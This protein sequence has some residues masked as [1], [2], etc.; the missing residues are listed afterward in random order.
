MKEFANRCASLKS[1][2]TMADTDDFVNH[3]VHMVEQVVGGVLQPSSH[4]MVAPH[5]DSLGRRILLVP[6]KGT[7]LP[8]NGYLLV[9]SFFLTFCVPLA[10]NDHKSA[11]Y[12][13]MLNSEEHR[14]LPAPKTGR[15]SQDEFPE[16]V[17]RNS[18]AF[19]PDESLQ[20]D[21]DGEDSEQA[22]HEVEE[23]NSAAPDE[24]NDE[25]PATQ[26]GNDAEKPRLDGGDRNGMHPENDA[27][28]TLETKVSIET[29][30]SDYEAQGDEWARTFVWSDTEC[31]LARFEEVTYVTLETIFRGKLLLTTDSVYFRVDDGIDVFSKEVVQ[32]SN[33][34]NFLRYRLGKLTEIHGR[35]YLLRPQALELFFVDCQ[36]VFFSFSSHKERNR[37]YAK[38]KNS[39]KA[40]LLSQTTSLNPR[41]AFKRSKLTNLWKKR[42]ISNFDY[43]KL[44][45]P[46]RTRLF[47]GSCP[48][49]YPLLPLSCTVMAL[50]RM[51]GRTFNDISQYPV[52]PWIL[53][54]L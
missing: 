30:D 49:F 6:N 52:F 36:E 45:W 2:A 34:K 50:N 43:R 28:S 48:Y 46:L 39:G 11:S 13:L 19:V 54:G 35:R 22:D 15:L 12:E 37:F 18:S 14:P 38:I 17:R 42:Q 44:V 16:F 23:S 1:N 3:R 20:D 5:G 9:E 24:V 26:A 33:D 32:V 41:I 4:W 8:H 53:A 25:Q 27:P 40:P 29:Q 21:L 51:A 31:I 47:V 10:F 7:N